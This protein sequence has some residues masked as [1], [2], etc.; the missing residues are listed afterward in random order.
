MQVALVLTVIGRDRTGLVEALARAVAEHGG[1]WL[2]SRMCRLGGEF[3]GI[4]RVQVPAQRRFALEQALTRL[5]ELSV[6]IREDEPLAASEPAR[7]ATLEVI[8]PD[9]PG[10]VREISHALAAR[11]VNVE[12]LATECLS[13]PMSGEALF[14]ARAKL[15]LPP[16]VTLATLRPALEAAAAQIGVDFTLSEL[17]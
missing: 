4:L 7:F 15:R 8:G 12:E 6:T 10:I 9:R 13:A 16:G 14:Q 1:N 3:A 17:K 11:G 5:G 2:E